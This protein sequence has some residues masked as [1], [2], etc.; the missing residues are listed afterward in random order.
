MIKTNAPN[1]RLKFDVANAARCV[2]LPASDE[3]WVSFK[4]YVSLV[5]YSLRCVLTLLYRAQPVTIS[6][7]F[8]I[9][10]ELN[11]NLGIKQST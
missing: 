11:V 7:T 8:G 10:R 1:C 4:F 2:E 6:S 9:T 3:G 5:Q